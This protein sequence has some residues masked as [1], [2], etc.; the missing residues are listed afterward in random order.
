MGNCNLFPSFI[1]VVHLILTL[2]PYTSMK[3]VHGG[4]VKI[5]CTTEI[6]DG[7]KLQLTL[8][9]HLACILGYTSST[10]DRQSL[11]FDQKSEYFAPHDP[12]LYLRYPKNLIIGCNIVNHSIF[13]GQHVKL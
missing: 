5:K 3:E 13:G 8:N 1:S 6:K 11:R 10:I 4:R 9:K 7:N 2:P 12:N